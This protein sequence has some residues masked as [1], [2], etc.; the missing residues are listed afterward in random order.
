MSLRLDHVGILSPDLDKAVKELSATLPIIAISQRFDDEGLG[1]SVQFL[2]D[3]AGFV[4]EVIAPFGENS[5]VARAVKEPN[6]LN[7]MAYRCADIKSEATRLRKQG[8]V[9]LGPARSAMAFDGALVQFLLC[10]PGFIIELIEGKSDA[11]IYEAVSKQ[12]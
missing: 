2:R 8:A 6:R 1:V 3:E 9:P 10:R 12:S 7:Q 11:R 4:V 5:P